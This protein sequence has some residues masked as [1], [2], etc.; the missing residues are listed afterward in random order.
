MAVRELLKYARVDELI[1]DPKVHITV[2]VGGG[3]VLVAVLGCPNQ[4]IL[5]SADESAGVTRLLSG[6]LGGSIY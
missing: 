6:K 5:W 4:F 1:S 2:R 3:V